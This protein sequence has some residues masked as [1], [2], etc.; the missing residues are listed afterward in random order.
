MH[1]FSDN[2][3]LMGERTKFTILF[4]LEAVM[5]GAPNV[6]PTLPTLVGALLFYTGLLGLVVTVSW[7]VFQAVRNRGLTPKPD[8]DLTAAYRAVK[9][10]LGDDG[11]AQIK[12]LAGRGKITLWGKPQLESGGLNEKTPTFGLE[13]EIPQDY[14]IRGDISWITLHGTE[15]T[16]AHGDSETYGKL[17]LNR[18]QLKK[19]GLLG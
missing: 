4:G 10:H 16:K 19:A 6:F 3:P 8:L 9:E 2:M 11:P 5:I 18:K 14:W 15:R 17:R 1:N 7:I 12:E 13:V